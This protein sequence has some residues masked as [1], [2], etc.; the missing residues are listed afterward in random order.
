MANL[1]IKGHATRGKEVIKIL[2]MLGGKN[3]NHCC[4]G[5]I[6]RIYF[7]NEYGYIESCDSM[8]RLD[9]CQYTLEEF[10]EK[11][12]YK[13]GYRVRIPE[14]ESEVCINKMLWNGNE[15]LYEVVV[16]DEVERYSAE[17]LNEFN[18]PNEEETMEKGD[19]AMAPNLVGE[20]YSE[21]RF[22]Y[23]IPQGYEFDCI[24]NNEIIIKPIKTQYP[25]TYEECCKVLFP[26]TVELG[27]V[28]FSANGYN[29]KLLVNFGELLICRDAYWEI[30]GKEMGLSKPWKPD[31]DGEL[32]P[33]HYVY[34]KKGRFQHSSYVL[35]F[36]T[37]EMRDTFYE[38][39]KNLIEECKELL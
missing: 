30:A 11:F 21:K 14:Y 2:K 22:G 8:H 38:N 5:F 20:D 33:E 1:A 15:V 6:N 12:P 23:K 3:D 25:K 13:V 37:R 17:E 36:P 27:K 9:Y 39:F 18:E 31:W 4:G 34:S 32:T 26:H 29:G 35:V 28:K 24:Q 16:D 7:I 19:K 10:I